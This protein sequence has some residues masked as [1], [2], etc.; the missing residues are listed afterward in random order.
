MAEDRAPKL[1]EPPDDAEGDDGPK[2]KRRTGA[3]RPAGQATVN[4]IKDG[5]AFQMTMLGMGIGQGDPVAGTIIV[6]GAEDFGEAWANV[7]RENKRVR[8]VLEKV[9]SVSTNGQAVFA[10]AAIAIPLATHWHVLPRA[11]FNPT[12][13]QVEQL[14]S[15]QEAGM[16]FPSMLE[17]IR[18]AQEQ[19]KAQA[20]AMP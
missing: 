8:E 11:W 18:R 4:R 20:K 13:A 3:G 12:A 19:A 9:V 5:L 6:S 15:L 16:D 10:T 1:V 17:T 7:A 2:R 14:E